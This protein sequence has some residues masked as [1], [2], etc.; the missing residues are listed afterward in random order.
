[1]SNPK[2]SPALRA[3]QVSGPGAVHAYQHLTRLTISPSKKIGNKYYCT[4]RL[5]PGAARGGPFW[6]RLIT[7]ALLEQLLLPGLDRAVT[8]ARC[9]QQRVHVVDFDLAAAVAEDARLLQ[10]MCDD[11]D[12]ISLHADHAGEQFLGH[13]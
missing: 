6:R 4:S 13:R 11:R 3:E 2:P 7:G 1:M 5:Y 8:F 10:R 9:L 12:R